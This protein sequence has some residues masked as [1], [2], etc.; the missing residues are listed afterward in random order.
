MN[1]QSSFDRLKQKMNMGS[2]EPVP[3]AENRSIPN[4]PVPVQPAF[5]DFNLFPE[6][7]EFTTMEWFY[8]KQNYTK[9]QFLKHAGASDA[10]VELDGRRVINFSSYNYLAL[11][12]DPRVKAAAQQAIEV[13]VL[14]LVDR[15]PAKSAFTKNLSAKLPTY[16]APKTL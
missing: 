5:Y 15:S 16:S 7:K 14:A 3:A 8:E 10:T 2:D 6:Y 11:A 1:Y 9:N 13:P 4:V 12:N